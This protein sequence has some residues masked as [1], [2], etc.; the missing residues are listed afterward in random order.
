[1]AFITFVCGLAVQRSILQDA[2]SKL[3]WKCSGFPVFLDAFITYEKVR[4]MLHQAIPRAV[5][6]T[7]YGAGGNAWYKMLLVP[8][9]VV[10]W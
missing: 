7:Q 6:G 3:S 10:Q 9:S 1:M 4:V 5:G 8:D 2:Y